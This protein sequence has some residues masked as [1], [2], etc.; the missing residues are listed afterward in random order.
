MWVPLHGVQ[1]QPWK[2][3]RVLTVFADVSV[4]F[5]FRSDN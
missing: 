2:V 1:V 4:T 5:A 3:G